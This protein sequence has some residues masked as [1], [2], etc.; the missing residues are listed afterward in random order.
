MRQESGGTKDTARRRATAG[1][2][3][4]GVSNGRIVAWWWH[5]HLQFFYDVYVFGLAR[6]GLAWLGSGSHSCQAEGEAEN[7]REREGETDGELRERS[8]Q[9]DEWLAKMF[10]CDHELD[11]SH[12]LK[13][14]VTQSSQLESESKSKLRKE[15]N[16]RAMLSSA[17]W[18]RMVQNG[19]TAPGTTSAG[20]EGVRSG[21]NYESRS[22]LSIIK[23]RSHCAGQT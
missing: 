11:L 9:Q 4:R 14:A 5:A 20:T 6:L 12:N 13:K 8:G 15:P 7:E 17:E 16:I 18:S 21:C 10:E 3:G 19:A 2:G 22:E 1:T 23:N